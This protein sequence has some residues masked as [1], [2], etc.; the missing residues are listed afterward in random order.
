MK[1]KAI[2]GVSGVVLAMSAPGAF[3]ATCEGVDQCAEL[4]ALCNAIADPSNFFL[5][6]RDRNGLITK[7]I[8]ADGKLAKG[9]LADADQKLDDIDA[10]LHQ[11]DEAAKPKISEEAH[12]ILHA[13][14]DDARICTN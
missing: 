9:K 11:L 6:E 7:T 10:K 1:L 2:V 12:D 13:A 4:T 14:V 5:N 8:D 3:A